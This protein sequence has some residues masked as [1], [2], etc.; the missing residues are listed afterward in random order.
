M[1]KV[2]PR[3]KASTLR[4]VVE[5]LFDIF[6]APN[7]MGIKVDLVGGDKAIKTS[8]DTNELYG[9]NLSFD[10]DIQEASVE[11][12]TK[13]KL[14]ILISDDIE[15]QGYPMPRIDLREAK[16]HYDGLNYGMTITL[17]PYNLEIVYSSKAEHQ[18]VCKFLEREFLFDIEVIIKKQRVP[19]K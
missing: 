15:A 12:P 10:Y 18:L 7:Y 19:L 4:K 11:N 16:F 17:T 9:M 1:M 2:I 14:L 5:M 3:T 6:P 13:E 8:F